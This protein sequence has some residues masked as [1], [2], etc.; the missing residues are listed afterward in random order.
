[1][2]DKTRSREERRKQLQNEK[3]KKTKKKKGGW[4]KK[5]MLAFL[6]LIIAGLVSGIGLFA[7][8]VSSA[9]ELDETLLKDPVSSKIYDKDKN[10][11]TEVGIE[12]RDYVTFDEIPDTV[13]NAVL[14]T[15][16]SRFY[17][18][19]GVD[20]L[21]LAS[22]VVANFTDGFGSQGASTITQQL[23]KRS[24]LTDEK[25]L[26]RKAQELWL[27]FQIERK[28]SKEEI[29][30]MY[31]N[32]IFYGERANGVATAAETYFGKSLDELDLAEAATLAGLPQSP[33]RY[34]P[35]NNPEGAETRRNVVLT[36]M[37]R[38]G[39]ISEQEM[40]EAQS[41]SLVA[42]LLP[43]EE[44]KSNTDSSYYNSFIDLV[45]EE[46]KEKTNHNIYTDGLEVYTTLDADAQSYVY[47]LLNSDDSAVNFPD[48]ELQAG[49][50][51]LDTTSGE[52]RAVGGGRNQTGA[53]TYNYA[54]DIERQPGSTIKPILDYGPA[55]EYLQWSTYEQVVDEKYS[56]SNGTPINNYNNKYHGQMSI[57]QALAKSYNIP[58]LKAFQA[59]GTENARKFGESLGLTLN[60]E[61]FFE[62]ASI[63]G[64][65]TGVSPLVMAGAYSA[66]GNEGVYNKPHTV[67]KVVLQDKTTTLNL[68][69]ES[70][71]VM[72][73][74]TAFMV[75]DM[76]K[77]VMTEGTGTA[78]NVP[79]LPVAGK[80]GTTN[81]SEDEL[82]KYGFPSSG[83]PDSWMVG[84]TTQYTTAVW[85]GYSKKSS[86]YLSTDSQ[87]LAKKIFKYVMTE[88]SKDVKTSDFKQ[89]NSVVKSAVEIGS[90]PAALPSKNT[91]SD[92]VTYEYFVKGTEPKTVSESYKAID[93][94]TNLQ[95]QY[96]EVANELYLTWDYPTDDEESKPSFKV[97][98]TTDSGGEV[99]VSQS[100][101]MEARVSNPTP[102]TIYNF[103][104]VAVVG[105]VSSSAATISIQVPA[106]SGEE[107]EEE[108]LDDT[109]TDDDSG[110]QDSSGDN[111][112]SDQS[113]DSNNSNPSDT[114]GNNSDTNENNNGANSG[115][116]NTS[117]NDAGLPGTLGVNQETPSGTSRL[118]KFT[119]IFQN[120]KLLFH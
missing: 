1:M 77:S 24:F 62:S 51:L 19:H 87:Q 40:K 6:I 68:K 78:A 26:K 31:I 48:D 93:A 84:Y 21:R 107:E 117:S 80:T 20:V 96:N 53:R 34:N 36:L 71:V 50:V 99:S 59:V 57:R 101:E 2:T 23:V 55:I 88:A 85:T 39:Y 66:F 44:R 111:T 61:E 112:D 72:K 13:V 92:Q 120:I 67:T 12:N 90:N 115:N 11:I 15:E 105:N 14:A 42:A 69:P 4:F 83:V 9:P 73:D 45:V 46:V 47:D 102:G 79:G 41:E 113:D 37:N 54:T 52:I 65:K 95:V 5:T 119:T 116:N 35:F 104:V 32:K 76:L 94:P 25:S 91:P 18:H 28:Y 29:F 103:S 74:Y 98:A 106:D 89:P 58:A 27:S 108:E 110:T 16:D 64:M 60:K 10:L 8:Y 3:S 30:E 56:Y 22:A 82:K 63:G 114:N 86:D 49:V 81:Y 97:S 33:S 109:L 7:Y 43:E 118:F 75:S 100:G 17:E 38:H 70:K